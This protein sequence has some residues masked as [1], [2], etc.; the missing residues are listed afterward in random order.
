MN[1]IERILEEAAQLPKDQRFT[2]AYRLLASN[3]PD[4]TDDVEREWE[5]AIRDRILR[6]DQEGAPA[7]TAGDVFAEL[8][9]KLA[10]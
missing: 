6:Y 2:L 10:K 5:I 7:I 8:D 3:E 4:P 1:S 9:R